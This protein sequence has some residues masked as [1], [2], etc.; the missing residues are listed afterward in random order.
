LLG[1]PQQITPHKM[2]YQ[3]FAESVTPI[4]VGACFIQKSIF[5]NNAL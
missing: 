2:T 1:L 4:G 5:A 3:L